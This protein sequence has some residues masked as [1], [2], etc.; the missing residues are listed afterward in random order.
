MQYELL[1]FKLKKMPKLNA[2]ENGT[3]ILHSRER[4]DIYESNAGF[5]SLK[6]REKEKALPSF[7]KKLN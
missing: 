6:I 4:I 7:T 3:S 5:Q 2:I 1:K